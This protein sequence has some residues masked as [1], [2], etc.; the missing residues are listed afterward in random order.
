AFTL[1]G[2]IHSPFKDG[3]LFVPWAIGALPP[4]AAGRGPL[5]LAF[6][7]GLLAILFV[8][9]SVWLSVSAGSRLPLHGDHSGDTLR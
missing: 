1:C 8:G 7:Y 2:V 6:A 4:E 9:W 3:R 5:H